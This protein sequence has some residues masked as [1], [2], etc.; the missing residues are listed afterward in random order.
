MQPGD[1]GPVGFPALAVPPQAPLPGLPH[2]AP[3]AWPCLPR[4]WLASPLPL[5]GLT[6]VLPST[7]L[8][9]FPP[10]SL[11]NLSPPPHPLP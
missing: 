10:P 1:S 11:L 7:Q 9:P 3:A 8:W 5:P 6:C 2:P 4:L